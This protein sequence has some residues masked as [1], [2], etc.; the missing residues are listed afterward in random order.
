MPSILIGQS[1]GPQLVLSGW[2]YSGHPVPVGNVY[3]KLAKNASGAI[4][5]G[6]SGGTTLNSGSLMLSGGGLLDGMQVN[7][8]EVYEIPRIGT[9]LSGNLSVWAWWDAACSGQA[10]LYWE[11]F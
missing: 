7:P 11:L 9:G 3:F 8:G 6:M 4:Y 10:R 2:P 5:L 1:G